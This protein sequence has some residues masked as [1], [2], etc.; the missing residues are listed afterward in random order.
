MLHRPSRGWG[1]D[2]EWGKVG[3]REGHLRLFGLWG[4]RSALPWRLRDLDRLRTDGEEGIPELV[5]RLEGL[6]SKVKCNL[7]LGGS[8][9]WWVR[10]GKT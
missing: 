9:S 1:R 5:T 4:V 2:Q 6:G 3:A 10:N 8:G 7:P